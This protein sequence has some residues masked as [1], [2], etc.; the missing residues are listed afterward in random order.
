M[1]NIYNALLVLAQLVV[2]KYYTTALIVELMAPAEN[3]DFFQKD[4]FL[5]VYHLNYTILLVLV[6]ATVTVEFEDELVIEVIVPKLLELV[7]HQF[8]T[9]TYPVDFDV[10]KFEV[11]VVLSLYIEFIHCM[12]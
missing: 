6:G 9:F 7:L 11:G 4:Y 10:I 5:T 2:S 8:V 12:N 3:Y 1:N